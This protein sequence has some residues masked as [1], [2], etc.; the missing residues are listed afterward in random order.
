MADKKKSVNLLPE[1]FR[2]DKNSKFLSSTLDQFIQTPDLER[3]DGY[4]GSKITPNYN[5]LTDF[6]LKDVLPLRNNYSLEP[7][8][9]FKDQN[10]NITDVVSYDDFLNEL[11]N[12]GANT[13]NIDTLLRSKFYS[14]DPLIDWDKLVNYN[15]YYWLPEG[16]APIILNQININVDDD[17]IGQTSYTMSNG[18]NLSNGMKITFAKNTLQESYWDNTY[19]VEGVGSSIKLIDY[20]LLGG[21]E[22]MNVF[23]NETFDSDKFDEYPFDGDKR[24]PLTAEYITIN[25]SSKDLNP[26]ARYNRWFHKEI[27]EITA[28]INDTIAVFPLN[29]RAQRPIIEFIADI[30]L[31]KFGNIGIKNVDYIDVTTTNALDTINGS[32]GYYVDGMLLQ[33]GDRIIFNAD[34]DNNVRGKIYKVIYSAGVSPTITLIEDAT[35]DDMN[36]VAVNFGNNY[37]GTSWYYES[38]VGKWIFSQ[39]HNKLNQPP[40]FDLFD[41]TG[42]SYTKIT[43]TNNFSGNQIFGYSVGSGSADS[44]LGFPLSY[45]NSVGVGSYL[46]KNYFMTDSITVV[47]NNQS[48][49]V[50]TSVTY[51]KMN[52]LDGTSTLTNVWKEAED[53]QIP[54]VEIQT[55]TTASTE[56]SL[57]SLDL[58]IDTSLSVTAYIN[59]VRIPS[60]VTASS[61]NVIVNFSN[62]IA[63]DET[64][65]FKILTNQLP[66]SNGFYETPLSLVSNPL[67]GPISDMTFS[68]LSD[69]A[70]AMVNRII[71]YTGS[72]FRDFSD[73]AKFGTRLIVNANPISFAE[74]FLGKKEHN[75]VDALRQSAN[76]YNQF[77]S[78]FLRTLL[79]VD[80]Q[81]TPSLALDYVLNE[82]NKVRDYRSPYYR[83]DMVGFGQDKT[84]RTF[85]VTDAGNIDY[86]VGIDFDLSL[87][88]FQSVLVYI[89]DIQQI[90]D[91]DYI[92]DKINGSV[93]IL[94]ELTLND[95]I[96][97]HVY[98]NTL[99]SYIP[100]TPTKLGLYPAFKPEI[101]QDLTYISGDVTVIK[102]HDGSI[103]AAYN[104]YRDLIILEL[105]KRIFNN[106]KVKYNSNIFDIKEIFP[107]AFRTTKFDLPNINSIL[108]EDYIRWAGMNGVDAYSNVSFDVTEPFSWNYK[109]GIDTVFNIQVSGFWRG[110]YKYFFDTDQPHTHPWEMLGHDNKPSWWDTY[111]SWTSGPKRTALISAITAGLT[112]EPP[113][114]TV[115]INYARPNFSSVVPVDTNGNLKNP[116][117]FLVSDTNYYDNKSAWVFGD[118]S[119]AETVWRRSSYWPFVSNILAVLVDPLSYCSKLYDVSRTQ[120]NS[121][122]QVTYTQDDLYLNPRKLLIDGEDSTQ[123]AG[124]GVY[125]AEIGKLKNQNYTTLLRQDLEYF[126]FNLFHKL[127]GFASKEKLQITIDSVDPVSTSPGLLLPPEDYSLI[128]NVSNPIKSVSISGIVVQKVNG[129]F[130]IKGYN[131]SDPYFEI[132]KPIKSAASGAVTVGGISEPFTEWTS[133]VNNGSTGLSAIDTTTANSN[134]T[135]RYYKQGQLIRYN[136]KFYR[137]KIGHNAESNFNATLF[138]PLSSLPVKG[139]ASAQLPSR[140]ESISAKIPYGSEFTTLQDVYDVIIGYG[141][142]LESQGFIFDEFNTDLG[143]VLDW[144]FTGKE[145]LYWTTQNWANNNL[146]ALS[147]FSNKLKYQFVN[148]VVDNISSGKY[149]YSLLKADGKPFPI[150]KFTLTR[151]D[152]YC[153]ISS[154]NTEEGLFFA[155]LNSIQKEH[156]LVF[157]NSTI[158]NDTIYDP[159]S[160]Y[161]QRR[162]KLSGFRTRNWNGDLFSPGFVYDSVEITDWKSYQVYL[163][164]EVV[165]YNG[166]YYESISRILNS[167]E[168]NFAQWVK[169]PEKPVAGLIPNFDYKINQFEDF[170]SLDIDNF[171]YNQQQL[172]QHLIGY[173]PRTYLDNIFTN[174]T[175]QYK[176]YQG[177]IKDKGTKNSIDK[178][179]KASQTLDKG[180]IQFNEEWAFRA[181]HYGGFNTYNELEF[182][183]TEGNS[184]ENPYLVKFVDSIPSQP[185]PLINYVRPTDCLIT[186][187]EY[188]STATF[189]T[190]VGTWTDTNLEL[191]TAGYVRLDDVTATAYNKS[192]LLDIANNSIIQQG[193]TFWVGFL[194]NGDWSVYRY[195][196]QSSD[197]AGVFVNSPGAAITFVTDTHHGLSVGDIVSVVN[198]NEQV[199]GV[200]VVSGVPKLNQFTVPSDL[201]SIEN[202]ELLAYGALF[203]FDESRYADFEDLAN[204]NDLLKLE[205]G[206]KFWVD[207]GL[208]G[209][210]QVYEKIKNY[211]AK[212]IESNDYILGQQLGH[213]VYASD[214]S[215]IMMVSSPSWNTTGTSSLGRVQAFTKIENAYR[216]DFEHTINSHDILYCSSSL[217]TEFGYSLAYDAA[218]ELYIAGAPSASNVVAA[219]TTGVVILSTGSGYTRSYAVE[220]LVKISTNNTKFNEEITNAVIAHPYAAAHSRFG[221]SIFVSQVSTTTSTVLLV[222]APGDDTSAA[223]LPG[224]V[225]AYHLNKNNGTVSVSAHPGGISFPSPAGLTAGDKWGYKISGSSNGSIIAISAPD[226]SSTG[227]VVVYTATNNTFVLNQTINPSYDVNGRFGL[228]LTVSA[229]GKYLIVA[230]PEYVS[231]GESKGKVS[232]YKIQSNGQYSLWQ[233]VSNPVSYNDLKF[234]SSLSIN[235]NEDTLVIS[236]LGTNRSK[237]MKFDLLSES[238]ETTF[239]SNTTQFTGPILDAGEVYVYNRLG[240]YFVPADEISNS[241]V[242][243][244]SRFGN[245]VASTNDAV[246]VGAPSYVE[247]SYPDTS[248][249]F[250]FD[251]INQTANSWNV[252]HEQEDTV[253]VSRLKRI[254][255]INSFDE[256]IIEYLEVIDPLKGKIAGI[257]D[258]E[259]KYKAAFDPAVY[260]IGRLGTVND[261]EINWLDEH[262]GDLWWDLSTAK[263]TWYE[264]GSE[265]FRKNNWGKLFPGATIDVYE[266]VKSDVLPSEWAA[267]ADTTDG[268]TRGISGQPKYPDNSIISVKQIYNNVT[269]SFENVYYFWVKNKVVVPGIKNRRLS[270]YQ[271]ASIIADPVANGL[272]FVEI[273]SKDAIAFANV[274]PM[275]SGNTINVSIAI[276]TIDNNIPKHTEWLLLTEGL[277]NSVPNVLLEKKLFDSLLGHDEHGNLVPSNNLTSRNRYGI[278]I[279]P[280][281]TLFK[282]R[283]QAVRN[284]ITFANSVLLS[285]QIAGNYSFN[286][287]NKKEEIPSIYA[288][289]YDS[290][291]ED[292]ETLSEVDTVNFKQAKLTCTIVNGQ[293][294]SVD[295]IDPGVGYTNPPSVKIISNTKNTASLLTE[296][297]EYGS[298]VNVTIFDA[299]Y[300]FTVAP[301]LEVRSHTV[302][303][304][305]NSEYGNRWTKHSYDYSTGNWIRI[306]TQSYNTPLYWKKIDWQSSNYNEFKNIKYTV[307]DLYELNSLT[308]IT[309][310]EYVKVNNNGSGKY[311]ILEKTVNGNFSPLYNIVYSEEGTIQLLDTLW[312]YDA[313]MYA[314]DRATLEET[315]YDQI[316]DLELYYILLALKNE[317][318]V[319]T[320]K[321]NWNLFF[322]AAVRY[323]LTEQKLLDWAFKTSFINVQNILGSL[324]QRPVYKLNNE[325]Y[326]EKYI[327]EVKPYHTNIRSYSSNY[328]VLDNFA[329]ELGA[330]Q[331]TDF[332]LPSYFNTLTEKFTT[333]ELGN[334][335]LEET[336]WKYWADNYK[337]EVTSV[338]IAN[339]GAG[340][341]QNPTVL[342]LPAPGD[343]G[344]GATAEAYIKNGSVYNI[345]VTNSGSNYTQ[346]PYVVISGGGPNV[347]SIASASA[348]ISNN[349]VRSNIIGMRFD[350]ISKQA[351]IEDVQVTDT[352]ICP[353]DKNKFTLTWLADFDKLKI[354]PTVDG[355]LVLSADYN[356]EYYTEE[357]AGHSKKYC[358]FVFLNNIPLEGQIFKI[359]YNKNIDLFNSIDRIDKYYNP[360]NTMPGKLYP[361]LMEGIEYPQTSLQGLSF[362]DTAPWSTSPYDT[363]PWGDLITSYTEAKLMNTVSIS[364][365]ELSVYPVTGITPGQSLAMLDS[366]NGASFRAGTVVESVDNIANTVKITSPQYYIDSANADAL[367]VGSTI[368]FKTTENFNGDFRV[369]DKVLILDIPT[370]GFSNEYVI[371]TC[372]NNTFNVTSTSVLSTTTAEITSI[373]SVRVYSVN[374][375]INPISTLLDT[376]RTISTG[377]STV[378]ITTYATYSD[379]V[380]VDVIASVGSITWTLGQTTD[381]PPRTTIIVDNLTVNA[382][383]TI[384]VVLLGFSNI[385]FWANNTDYTNLDSSITG[386]TWTNILSGALGVSPEDMI[387]DGDAF[388]NPSS[389]HAPEEYVPGH[390]LDSVGI[391]VYTTPQITYPTVLSGAIPV[392]AGEETRWLVPVEPDNAIGIMVY[393]NG[394][395]FNRSSSTDF[396]ESNQFYL[397]GTT[398]ILPAQDVSG[399]AFYTTIFAGESGPAQMDSGYVLADNKTASTATVTISSMLNIDDVNSVYVTVDGVEIFP[400]TGN[401][402][403][404]ILRQVHPQNNRASVAVII[405]AEIR[406]FNV[407]AW[408]FTSNFTK[409][410]KFNEETY[411]VASGEF[412]TYKQLT[413]IPS[414]LEPYSS[415]VIVTVGPLAS[416]TRLRP[417]SVSYYKIQNNNISFDIDNKNDRPGVYN[418]DNVKVYVNGFALRPGFDYLVDSAN[419][420]VSVINNSLKLGDVIAIES[421]VDY[422]YI[423]IGD[424]VYFTP[425]I[426]DTTLQIISFTDN[427][428]MNIRTER[429]AQ[430]LAKEY[431]LSLP[432]LNQNYVWVSIGNRMLVSGHEFY[433]QD[434]LMTIQV[435]DLINTNFA[436]EV[437]ITTINPPGSSGQI[438]GYRIFKDIFG[439][440]HYKR[441]SKYHTTELELPLYY[442]DTEIHLKNA[443]NLTH[444]N[445]AQN[446]PGVVLIDGERIEY[447]TKNGNVLSQLRRSTLGTGPAYYSQAG[448]KVIDQSIKQ[449]INT[450][451]YKLEQNIPSSN[452]NTYIISTSTLTF[453]AEMSGN[454]ISLQPGINAV[455]QVEVYYGGRKLRKTPLVVHD[456]NI[457]YDSS[458]ESL[459]TIEPEFYIT[460]S[461]QQLMLNITE[462]ITTGTRITIV[463]R[464]GKIWTTDSLL[465]SDVEQAVFL[466]TRSAELPNS[467]YY[468][469]DLDLTDENFTPLTTD[470]GIVIQGL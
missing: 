273:L 265:I 361:M 214:N 412:W 203:K 199:N 247:T 105:E 60:T 34:I 328:T 72:N 445:P 329:G 15:Q 262:V 3:I 279:R 142:W 132:L 101:Y 308:E 391:N 271:V 205:E 95:E 301:T 233:I 12:Q 359:I 204:Y 263:Y 395:L 436:D 413:S 287:L 228:D 447:F 179:S 297:N 162:I 4:I 225:Y 194:E 111:Y 191:T 314:Y 434:D 343:F 131:V 73:Y 184:L 435:S 168:F 253:D 457:S 255:L 407:E 289:E 186:P 317:I 245:S 353:G 456:K 399:R 128:L 303:V 38:A 304:Q 92:F 152:G 367:A 267:V 299:G 160:G 129:N 75:V 441:L 278:G 469:G 127:G 331:I 5:P 47:D 449:T 180:A 258:Q 306:K 69:H 59:E 269:G 11:Y 352:F 428:N 7:A 109:N 339:S 85:T 2:T 110:L 363:R 238:G 341:T 33:H 107:G 114:T 470:D 285:N 298:V 74:I 309:D 453:S 462:E 464:Q 321:V 286:L 25:R 134:P 450:V 348:I 411:V 163:P 31:Y 45:Q 172:A 64:V 345:V 202:A 116:S 178:L 312:D 295:I 358:R 170:Y 293:I 106:I 183:L 206:E 84:I 369:G 49:L 260:S 466:R 104:D 226:F 280:Q 222:G 117:E 80:D 29:S 231:A 375:E 405:P 467:Y 300:N 366:V 241:Q 164:G 112:G 149:E 355:K 440:Q 250:I 62:T 19:I 177:F 281:Q 175:S 159:E 201:T 288:R 195:I 373:S 219:N 237:L 224:N 417:P 459:T 330:A 354:I 57:T 454:G 211:S 393:F 420:T 40:L 246:Y 276:D 24:L 68:E 242:I 335:L 396:T 368:V 414:V 36:S 319:N 27:I 215:P 282:D 234:G 58:P 374:N 210:W 268:L 227:K 424:T 377:T 99:G 232:I 41:S 55:L 220:G 439:R 429:F 401:G 410:N 8:L 148:S 385:A 91:S 135:S 254:S 200:H 463:Q 83:S 266:W 340:Y 291:V 66:N 103:M 252:L 460:T 381:T 403:G 86:P 259:L 51:L 356:I 61:N 318:F 50:S 421:L 382:E 342:I 337:F 119:P 270:S 143:E 213:T 188:V 150:D 176:F 173:T 419:E 154:V 88:S 209:K 167:K 158:F 56:I 98:S 48:K 426:T 446:I 6:Y 140:F 392:E 307:S 79:N 189:I 165:R 65:V 182:T 448:T 94:T 406:K 39:Q 122:N 468:G 229:S 93:K 387:I 212:Y 243:N 108:I 155:T 77:K 432:A 244:G 54:I 193:N 372:S 277:A 53:Y 141:A 223:S 316:P 153:I 397:E 408:F 121:L 133:T 452:T 274:Q 305:V 272:K 126:D 169:L 235:E 455:D 35:P 174:P 71:G 67:N 333:I 313:G 43:D 458:I 275:L 70:T 310:L 409:F 161:K 336:P 113:S 89:N 192:S 430:N 433:I 322:F 130:V 283:L 390:T 166:S 292:V 137:V 21:Y 13:S 147:P 443:N 438:I 76:H 115:N 120:L 315:L 465:T 22:P 444:P 378:T 362:A 398:L 136:G 239:D 190:S 90:V 151:E 389:S 325:E 138:Q 442:T 208:G 240:E 187:D 30:Q 324:D 63:K 350:R 78:N 81:L 284:L 386:G 320:L 216:K 18:Y 248:K 334:P 28:V 451:E 360:D 249:L 156:A 384:D 427:E 118:Q 404:Y 23:Y 217:I 198:F 257:A 123:I 379:V 181:G 16:P 365:V 349:K 157:N 425:D 171:D 125:I 9:V 431:K 326:F 347:T 10:S 370:S 97:I 236:S 145:F 1:Y 139:G 256:E 144:K 20:N 380:A 416:R 82:M 423:V 100:P 323:A 422:D 400:Y 207:Q 302:I 44:V 251:K 461:T 32:V 364:D 124:F 96:T 261:T 415:Q 46:F 338:Q 185:D 17:I 388:I 290:I 311:I 402:T 376:V 197:V 42:V 357:Y 14:Y 383:T 418:L 87:L 37:A 344:N 196:R 351:E 146:I 296:L 26:W 230:D 371:T 264:Q 294:Y 327:K 346:T 394:T 221:H 52:N 102:G 332:D 218:K 437:I